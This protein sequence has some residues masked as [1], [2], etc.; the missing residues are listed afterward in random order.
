[1]SPLFQ[2]RMPWV[3]RDQDLPCARYSRKPSR[4]TEVAGY[5]PCQPSAPARKTLYRFWIRWNTTDPYHPGRSVLGSSFPQFIYFG[6][7]HV[8]DIRKYP[9]R[10]NWSF[11]LEGNSADPCGSSSCQDWCHSP[12][13]VR[14]NVIIKVIFCKLPIL[15]TIQTH[16]LSF[17]ETLLTRCTW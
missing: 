15:R 12:S 7:L 4:L 17:I 6:I 16:I 1:M 14:W 5:Y 8:G 2:S 3:P 11:K 9:V 13:E 10:D